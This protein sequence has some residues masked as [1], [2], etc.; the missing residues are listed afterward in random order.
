MRGLAR[1]ASDLGDGHVRLTV[2]QNLLLSGIPSDRLESAKARV[3]ELGL[4]W[5]AT[6]VR[7]GLVAC[8]G[9]TGCKLANANTKDAAERIARHVEAR[10][11]LDQPINIHVTGCPNSC[12]QH[13]I[14]DIGLVGTKVTVNSEGDTVEGYNVWIGG[15][16]GAAAAIGRELL[17]NVTAEHV[18]VVVERVLKA[19]L[20]HRSGPEEAF[21]AFARRHD[22]EALKAAIEGDAA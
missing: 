1:I 3:E 17:A 9:N 21:V 5:K 14:G 16:H 7:A 19:Y 13:T 18:P 11:D 8:T 10:L 4:D 22:I 12:A 15:G 20:R 2:W 6:S